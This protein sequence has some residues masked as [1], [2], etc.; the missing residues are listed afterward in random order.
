MEKNFIWLEENEFSLKLTW[1][2]KKENYFLLEKINN[3]TEL[4]KVVC[5]ST[6]NLSILKMEKK[7][8]SVK[9]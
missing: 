6:F 2:K 5:S 9:P 8:N 4:E 1:F 7:V 3:P